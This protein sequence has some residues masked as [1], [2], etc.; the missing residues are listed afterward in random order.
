[1]LLIVNQDKLSQYIKISCVIANCAKLLYM[2]LYIFTPFI[3]RTDIINSNFY[4][5]RHYIQI[6]I[7]LTT[8]AYHANIFYYLRTRFCLKYKEIMKSQNFLTKFRRISQY[9]IMISSGYILCSTP[10]VIFYI[11]IILF[12][13]RKEIDSGDYARNTFFSV[14]Y[15]ILYIDQILLK[16]L[17]VVKPTSNTPAPYNRISGCS[18]NSETESKMDDHSTTIS[19]TSVEARPQVTARPM[20]FNNWSAP[21][22]WSKPEY[23]KPSDRPQQQQQQPQPQLQP[24]PTS[25]LQTEQEPQPQPTSPLQTEQELPSSPEQSQ[26]GNRLSLLSFHRQSQEKRTSFQQQ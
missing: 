23:L 11:F 6:L 15:Y 22:G 3:S 26:Q 12:D 16:N 10:F 5:Y 9:R 14:P 19:H 2:G 4:E 7:S 24:Q 17:V 8:I 25:P 1:M 13:K 18:A 20:L 21:E